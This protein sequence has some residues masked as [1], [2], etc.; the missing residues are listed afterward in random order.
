MKSLRFWIIILI[1]WLIFFF[2]IERINSPV[3]IRSYTYIFVAVVVALTL[4][5]PGLRQI[6]FLMLL[7]VPI[8]VFLSLKALM[9]RGHWYENLLVGYALPLTVTQVSA[10]ILTGLLARQINYGLREFEEVIANITFDYIGRLPKPFSE[11]QG[12]MYREVKRAR[13]YHRPVAVIALNVSEADFQVVLPQMVKEVQQAMMRE[14]VMAGIA[15]IL[16]KN[17]HDFD[18]IAVRDNN[19]ILVLPEIPAEEATQITQRRCG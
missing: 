8:P 11:G 1:I 19:F 15:R 18:T 2:N 12:R 4:A 16:D 5:L 10:I 6:P 17:I 7:L 9:E 14:Y 3:N 13:R